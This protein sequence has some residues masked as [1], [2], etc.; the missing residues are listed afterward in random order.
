MGLGL[1][2]GFGGGVVVVLTLVL[3]AVVVVMSVEVVSV[4][5]GSCAEPTGTSAARTPAVESASAATAIP[6]ARFTCSG[7]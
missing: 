5:D 3:V 7:V 2:L 4:G 6:S 1:G